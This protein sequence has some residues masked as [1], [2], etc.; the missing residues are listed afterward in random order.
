MYMDVNLAIRFAQLVNAAYAVDPDNVSSLAGQTINAGEVSYT[1]VTTV[2]ANDLATDIFPGR[3]S[4]IVSIG[5]VLQVTGGEDIVIAIRGT[6]GVFEWVQDAR[7]GMVPCPF[8]ASAG[9]TEDGF[10]SMYNSLRTQDTAGSPT[11]AAALAG[12]PFPQPVSAATPVT[13]CGHSLGGALVTLLA[14]DVA[15]NTIFTNPTV[16]SYAS[17]RTGDPAFVAMYDHLVPNTFRIANRVDL[18]PKL[19]LPPLYDHVDRLFEVNPVQ[20]LPLPPK[21]LI[22]PDL[23]CEHILSSYLFLLSLQSGGPVI[24][25][26]GNCA[27]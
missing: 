9:N 21:I 5:L 24:P 6:E 3:A 1:V 26:D 27:L 12:L 19:P 20:F 7:F 18:V 23:A 2:F 11:L 8:L 10:T 14:L 17:P 4:K 25:L 15:A 13:I 16:Y 22:R